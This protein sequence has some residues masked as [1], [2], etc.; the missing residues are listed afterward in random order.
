ML[1]TAQSEPDLKRTQN[2]QKRLREKLERDTKKL[3]IIYL[4]P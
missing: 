2:T 1:T 3:G 4:T